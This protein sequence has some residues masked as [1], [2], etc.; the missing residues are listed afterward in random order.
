MNNEHTGLTKREYFA[1]MALQGILANSSNS[2]PDI[3]GV[4]ANSQE[5]GFIASSMA[6][7]QAVQYADDILNRLEEHNH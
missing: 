1:A 2:H 5:R 4:N 3:M 7:K 6:T